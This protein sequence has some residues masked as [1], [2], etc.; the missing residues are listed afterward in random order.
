MRVGV[1]LSLFHEQTRHGDAAAGPQ[2]AWGLVAGL[3]ADHAAGSNNVFIVA[4]VVAL[5]VSV[6]CELRLEGPDFVLELDDIVAVY[7][8][9]LCGVEVFTSRPGSFAGE[10]AR[11]RR[12]ASCL[13]LSFKVNICAHGSVTSEEPDVSARDAQIPDGSGSRLSACGRHGD[14]NRHHPIGHRVSEATC[15]F[16]QYIPGS[17]EWEQIP[18][19]G[20]VYAQ[21]PSLLY[22]DVTFDC[23]VYGRRCSCNQRKRNPGTSDRCC[24]DRNNARGVARRGEGR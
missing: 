17:G 8:L 15:A 19:L 12:I 11:Q 21:D 1:S 5:I 14:Q 23:H 10:T 24:N 4:R 20:G 7:L 9:P 22:T 6:L 16:V 18:G 2:I 13:S 3:E